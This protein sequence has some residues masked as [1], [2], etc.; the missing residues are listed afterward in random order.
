MAPS[1]A[2]SMAAP[3]AF[4]PALSEPRPEP[5]AAAEAP[6]AMTLSHSSSER[7]A[8]DSHLLSRTLGGASKLDLP[9]GCTRPAPSRPATALPRAP[10]AGHSGVAGRRRP[11]SAELGRGIGVTKRGADANGRGSLVVLAAAD[12]EVSPYLRG[13]PYRQPE[14]RAAP[15]A[16]RMPN[17][18]R[19]SSAAVKKAMRLQRL[20]GQPLRE[21]PS[22]G[23]FGKKRGAISAPYA[24]TVPPK[25]TP[26]GV[27]VRRAWTEEAIERAAG[28]GRKPS[29]SGVPPIPEDVALFLPD[30][31]SCGASSDEATRLQH[32]CDAVG[33]EP[34][35]AA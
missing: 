22:I 33:A 32:A 31:D 20:Y 24:I 12:G 7:K 27:S 16:L 21:L 8:V 26:L 2:P 4:P 3:L 23:L 13:L 29:A 15:S 18:D 5:T 1:M 9:A 28:N 19:L 35:D 17:S 25:T 30:G 10:A 6:P 14:L 11:H 34:A